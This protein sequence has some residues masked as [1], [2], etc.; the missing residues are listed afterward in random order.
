MFTLKKFLRIKLPLDPLLVACLC[1]GR[2]MLADGSSRADPFLCFQ[3][4]AKLERNLPIEL[5]KVSCVASLT[6]AARRTP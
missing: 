6:W 3:P 5:H 1:G 4:E 2:L